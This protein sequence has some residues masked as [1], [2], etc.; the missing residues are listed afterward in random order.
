MASKKIIKVA[1]L[2]P[3]P[4]TTAPSQRFRF[5][6][7]LDLLPANGIEYSLHS[8]LDE[9]TW[10]ILYKKGHFLQKLGGILRGFGRRFLLLPRLLKVDFVFIHR[11]AAPLGPPI[12]EWLIAKI[13]RK[14]IIFD[15]DDAIWLPNTS[16]NNR[17]A[18]F[19]KFH[20]KTAAICRWAYKISA[21]NHYLADYAR[22]FN[23][24]VVLNPTTI[25]TE[26]WHNPRLF[27]QPNK[28]DEPPTI[29]WTGTHS[30]IK[31][32]NELVPI[33]QNLEKKYLFKFLVISNQAPDF[34]LNS[35]LYVPWQKETEIIDLMQMDFGV[36]PLTED[37]WAKGK[38]GF[39][40]LQYMALAIP[41]LVSPV[42]VNTEIVDEG[43]NGFIC[44][45]SADWA[46]KIAFLLANPTQC[47]AI[48]KAAREK[49]IEKYSVIANQNNFVLLFK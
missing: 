24:R 8:F 27:A 29:G 41:A 25:D 36:M 46:Q 18:A 14:K 45:S 6:Q 28:Q 32:L 40:A 12:F 19:I 3:Y 37:A 22:Q 7:Y 13:L 48:G 26:N 16:E 1:F 34:Q 43:I 2:F 49:I 20:S 47:I 39:K 11:E 33:L 15:F 30:T 31:Y 38:C 42:G 9:S 10:A 23:P 5:E 35:L 21:G 44:E 4:H 17:V